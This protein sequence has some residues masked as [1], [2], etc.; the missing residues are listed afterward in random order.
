MQS[1]GALCSLSPSCASSPALRALCLLRRRQ[2]RRR[3]HPSRKQARPSLPLATTPQNTCAHPAPPL[4]QVDERFAA[5]AADP[6]EG[7][8]LGVLGEVF[9]FPAFRGL[10]LPTIQ[11]VLGGESLLSIMPT[12]EEARAL[13]QIV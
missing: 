13:S 4:L 11:R 12:G 3:L 6:S 2:R 9:G 8:L 10:Q 5:T 7:A 1:T